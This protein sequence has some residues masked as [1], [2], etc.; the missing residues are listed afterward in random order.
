MVT[1]LGI[2]ERI[3]ALCDITGRWGGGGVTTP[4]VLQLLYVSTSNLPSCNRQRDEW[5]AEKHVHVLLV[6]VHVCP[7]R[8]R[9]QQALPVSCFLSVWEGAESAPSQ[10]GEGGTQ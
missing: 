10:E 7:L 2:L 8:S 5:K 4:P 6:H 1:H 9:Q 3:S